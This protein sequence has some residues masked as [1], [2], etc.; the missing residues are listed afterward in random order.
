MSDVKNFQLNRLLIEL[1][2]G[3]TGGS[4]NVQSFIP[5]VIKDT[6]PQ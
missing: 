6:K 4:T 1:V 3:G 5:S 2:N